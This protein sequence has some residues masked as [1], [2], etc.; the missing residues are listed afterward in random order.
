MK[1]YVKDETF[2]LDK[3]VKKKLT[4]EYHAEFMCGLF[5]V[6][7]ATLEKLNDFIRDILLCY[8]KTSVYPFITPYKDSLQ[9]NFRT[10]NFF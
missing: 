3:G 10:L 9:L 6:E 8:G 4:K 2:R 1:I 7:I 5:I